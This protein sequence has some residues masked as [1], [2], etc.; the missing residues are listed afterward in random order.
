MAQ[1]FINILQDDRAEMKI[2]I[3]GLVPGSLNQFLGV[4]DDHEGHGW[5]IPTEL[6]SSTDLI[7]IILTESFQLNNCFS[8]SGKIA[9]F[10]ISQNSIPY[11][12]FADNF[13]PRKSVRRPMWECN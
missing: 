11:Y 2:W 1:C 4:F 10:V 7:A 9:N 3:F 12:V 13:W 8:W 5:A 6:G